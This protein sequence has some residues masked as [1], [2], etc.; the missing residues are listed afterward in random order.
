MRFISLLSVLILSSQTLYSQSDERYMSN[1]DSVASSLGGVIQPDSTLFAL[2]VGAEDDLY[3]ALTR[4]YQAGGGSGASARRGGVA[5]W[6]TRA[7]DTSMDWGYGELI[8][9]L[10]GGSM[11]VSYGG[12]NS[13]LGV[14]AEYSHL[15][16]NSGWSVDGDLYFR[17]GRNQ[18]IDGVFATEIYP[19]LTLSNA[20]GH[21]HSLN[22]SISAPYTMRGL[23]SATTQECYA[24][25]SNPNYNPSWGL[26][27]GEVR[28]SRV[29]RNFKPSFEL[30]Y[31]RPVSNLTNIALE[32]DIDGGT[33]KVS[34]LGWYDATNPMPDYYNKM[35][36]W[37]SPTSTA[38]D[39][40][41]AVW[42]SN[43]TNYTQVDWTKL[44]LANS[45][46]DDGSA[47]Y[48][49]EDRVTQR[50]D[51][52][53]RLL[54]TTYLSKGFKIHYGVGY[55]R[56]EQRNY[57]EMRDL[58]GAEYLL[59]VDQWVSDYSSVSNNLQNNLL[60]PNRKVTEGDKFG[61][62]YSFYSTQTQLLMG[63]EIALGR[64]RSEL[65]IR[66]GTSKL[67]RQGHYEKERFAGALSY[68]NSQTIS[69]NDYIG[70]LKI[71]YTLRPKHTLS[72]SASMVQNPPLASSL[73]IDAQSANI[74]VEEPKSQSINSLL[75]GYSYRGWRFSL[76][77]HFSYIYVGDGMQSWQFYD[78]M[79]GC[80]CNAVISDIA[81]TSLSGE[82]AASLRLT[83]Q[84]TL[85]STL[86]VGSYTYSSAPLVRL[87]DYDDMNLV[88]T[89]LATGVEGCV[90]GNTPQLAATL[91]LTYF[92]SKGFIINLN[93]SLLASRYIQP[94]MV[95][96]TARME[97]YATNVDIW[98]Q[99]A[100]GSI[101][102]VS[103][104]V[105]RSLYLKNSQ[106]MVARMTI[107]NLLSSGGDIIYAREANRILSS[108]YG[109]VTYSTYAQPSVYELNQG[110]SIYISLGYYF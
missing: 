82:L 23:R 84:L 27:N 13:L 64:F 32:L 102:D 97:S 109:G 54:L 55:S 81:T 107:E 41:K 26:Y 92:A 17:T 58:L 108:D 14:G 79:S 90:V 101:C 40:T 20:L 57:K 9:P 22:L 59:D 75:V 24:L 29:A 68:G 47:H 94:S 35:P 103:I 37:L 1:Y 45:M 110:R 65:T 5:W 89:S 43:D 49:L 19:Y 66:G 10:S 44:E 76:D 77:A 6:I 98:E 3:S 52:E 11:R 15:F 78:D 42:Q 21:Q 100:L 33:S 28:N 16:A 99:E 25:T 38:Y 39:V 53:A 12:R 36:S 80:Y 70:A 86:N 18:D 91:S 88:A 61:Y 71:A 8:Q 31:Q 73:F 30:R 62:D 106:R 60:D 7:L 72:L 95:R 51:T 2:S 104:S 67:Y 50:A 69:L 85:N 83:S 63:A 56:E 96:R 4:Y 74:I 34:R 46:S 87:Y 93:S 48:T 105:S